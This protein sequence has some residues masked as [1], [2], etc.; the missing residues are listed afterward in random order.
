MIRDQRVAVVVVRDGRMNG[1]G[2]G[3]GESNGYAHRQARI[4]TGR[5][6]QRR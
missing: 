2:V 1:H 4:K 5:S 3:G 6:Q